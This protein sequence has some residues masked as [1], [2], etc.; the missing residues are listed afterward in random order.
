[1]A[2]LGWVIKKVYKESTDTFG[3]AWHSPLGQTWNMCFFADIQRN[4]WYSKN[5]MLIILKVTF[6]PLACSHVQY[7]IAFWGVK[8]IHNWT[9]IREGLYVSAQFQCWHRTVLIEFAQYIC[10]FTFT[11]KYIDIYVLTL[12][13]LFNE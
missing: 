4:T 11:V 1:M 6:F 12:F 13:Y 7:E 9:R 2:L 5:T 3:C 8:G 10:T